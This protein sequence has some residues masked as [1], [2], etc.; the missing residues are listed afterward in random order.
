MKESKAL[1]KVILKGVLQYYYNNNKQGCDVIH[2]TPLFLT[3]IPPKRC[4]NNALHRK[5]KGELLRMKLKKAERNQVHMMILPE[6]GKQKLLTY[7]DSF[8]DLADVFIR[9]N[10]DDKEQEL[11]D[12]GKD[13]STFLYKRKAHE[14][15][16]IMA[17]HLNEMAQIMTEVAQISF[18]YE[19]LPQRTSRQVCHFLKTEGIMVKEIHY[20]ENE[21]NRLEIGATLALEKGQTKTAEE[22]ANLLS[23]IFDK[24]L[25]VSK[26]TDYYLDEQYRDFHFLEEPAF[27]AFV[28][29]AKAIKENESVS[30]DNFCQFETEKNGLTIMLSDGMGSGKKASEDSRRVLDLMERLLSAGFSGETAVQMVNTSLSIGGTDS[31]MSTLDV[32][33]IDLHDGVVELTKVGAASTF[34]KRANL[35]EQI[36]SRNLPLGVFGRLEPEVTKRKLMDGDYIVMVS[37]GITDGLSHEIGEDVLS[38]IISRTNLE[39]PK[40]IAAHILN[41]VIRTCKG[42]IRDDMTVIVAGVWKNT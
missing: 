6:Y 39:N 36:S 19:A 4:Y 3:K 41:Y 29:S 13:R 30:G 26:E 38:E 25:Q 20:I 16:E 5:S 27:F 15:R 35:V 40:E 34:I 37:D 2:R 14:S 17:D 32:C 11:L 18:A 22:V 24:R 9:I 28:G 12:A 8:K 10:T 7:A 23:V 31:N 42:V 21:D 1:F 33:N